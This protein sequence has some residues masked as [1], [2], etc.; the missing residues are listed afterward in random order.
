MNIITQSFSNV[1]SFIQQNVHHPITGKQKKIVLIA[2]VAL[3]FWLPAIFSNAFVLKEILL[4][5]QMVPGS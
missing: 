1:I 3:A 4:K 5:I 2:S